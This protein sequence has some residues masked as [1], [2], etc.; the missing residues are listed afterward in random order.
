VSAVPTR[1]RCRA[2][3]AGFGR[4]GMRDL[5]IGRQLVR[6]MEDLS[7]DEGV[8]VED[9]SYA[10]P[11]VLHR[12]QELDPAKVV[13]VGAA[14][15]GFDVPGS[16]R[17][18]RVDVEPPRPDDVQRSL[19]ESVQ[20]V[21]DIDH[22]L[23]IARHYG[24]LP[25]ETVIIEVEPADCSFGPGFSEDLLSAFDAMVALVRDELGLSEDDLVDRDIGRDLMTAG[26]ETDG[27][28]T[29]TEPSR[30]LEALAQ[31]ARQHEESRVVSPHRGPRLVPVTP[32][33]AGLVT[34]ARSKPWGVNLRGAAGGD[35]FD[36]IPLEDGWWGCVVGDV[37]GRGVE[38]TASM[39]DLRA[40]VRAYA[41][42]EGPFPGRVLDHLDRLARATGLGADAT[43][44]YLAYRPDMGQLRVSNAG[45]CPPLIVAQDGGA[46]FVLGAIGDALGATD[47]RTEERIML[48]RGATVL[49]FTDGLVETPGGSTASALEQLRQ[50]VILGPT[51]LDE[52]CDHVLQVC[53]P[54][55][56]RDDDVCLLALRSS[57]AARR[58]RPQSA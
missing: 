50:A 33:G 35:W 14:A 3:V 8:V 56:R 10:A 7:W 53:T 58:V 19:E 13:L 34:A 25:S 49:L 39:A 36:V 15:R 21:V 17:R 37:A 11:L 26:V 54:E 32:D 18:Y 20:G 4:P 57:E 52:L 6:Y 9:L 22:T 51:D 16:L 24:A 12:L 44:V 42:S 45:N 40:A 5:D 31:Y 47:Q 23:A 48:E 41:I 55:G 30:A 27:P 46:R 28:S 1:T 2:L 38:A 29:N 43:L